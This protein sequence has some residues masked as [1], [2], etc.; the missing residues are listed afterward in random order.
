MTFSKPGGHQ[1]VFYMNVATSI[2]VKIAALLCLRASLQT[3]FMSRCILESYF[4]GL[5][6]RLATGLLFH[7]KVTGKRDGAVVFIAGT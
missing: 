4:P 6:T 1:S 2:S 3:P 5:R 7:I